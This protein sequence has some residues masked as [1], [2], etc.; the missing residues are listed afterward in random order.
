MS[1]KGC[2]L[3]RRRSHLELAE[4]L[5]APIV[6][7]LLGKGAV[8][9]D[10]ELHMGMLGMHG[11]AYA[12]KAVANCDLIMAI[13]ARWDDRITGKLSEFCTDAVKLH[14]DIDPAEFGKIID[15]DLSLAV[16]PRRSLKT[17]FCCHV[18]KCDSEAWLAMLAETRKKAPLTYPKKGG[19]RPS[20]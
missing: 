1:A 5:Q 17:S 13:G 14:I 16:T 2:H 12:N 9:E 3:R 18:T 10:H 6:N 8:A 20:T 7:T 11:T 15:P 19:L 4:K